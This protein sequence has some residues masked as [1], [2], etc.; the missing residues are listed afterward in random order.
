VSGRHLFRCYRSTLG[1]L[2]VNVRMVPPVVVN[3]MGGDTTLNR[4]G[5]LTL[6]GRASMATAE[7][8]E[9]CS[10]WSI[11]SFLRG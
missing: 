3:H 11:T 1:R 5:D 8:S 4:A 10:A 6:G 2:G 7:L 9:V